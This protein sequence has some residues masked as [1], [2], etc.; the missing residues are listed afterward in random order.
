MVQ[1]GVV[2][3]LRE[4]LVDTRHDWP[5][6]G[7]AL[8]L[9]QYSHLSLSNADM[10]LRLEDAHIYDTMVV[11]VNDCEKRETKRHLWEA[12]SLMAMSKQKMQSIAI[13][14]KDHCYAAC[15]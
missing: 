1:I 11:F 9:L 14:V 8:A 15:A 2:D 12:I 10:F 6:N 7:A 13:I 4:I 5:T 3:I